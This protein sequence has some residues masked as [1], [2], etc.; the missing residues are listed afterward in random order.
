[1]VHLSFDINVSDG[2]CLIISP[3]NN[4]QLSSVL[5]Q[6]YS[7]HELVEPFNGAKLKRFKWQFLILAYKYKQVALWFSVMA[8]SIHLDC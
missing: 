8:T 7:L 3:S 4:S 6:P 1:M 2:I 5:D